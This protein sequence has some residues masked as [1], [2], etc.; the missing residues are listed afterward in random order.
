MTDQSSTTPAKKTDCAL[1]IQ[2]V[3]LNLWELSPDHVLY[4]KFN[5]LIEVAALEYF[6]GRAIHL[7]YEKYAP[8]LI[9]LH[10]TLGNEPFTTWKVSIDDCTDGPFTPEVIWRINDE[11]DR[12]P[13]YNAMDHHLS[14]I[15]EEAK[16]NAWVRDTAFIVVQAKFQSTGNHIR[17]QLDP[18][19]AK[20]LAD[21]Q[22]HLDKEAA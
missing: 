3:S 14:L 17:L 20:M 5:D 16:S 9:G 4:N 18:T 6:E 19:R 13:V 22:A 1:P 21:H 11:G 7:T 12:G 8:S 10:I 15:I 2:S